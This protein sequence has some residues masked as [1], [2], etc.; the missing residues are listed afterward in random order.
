MTEC[1]KEKRITSVCLVD[2]G[3]SNHMSGAK[4]MFKD[5]DKSQKIT[6]RLGDNNEMMV[7]GK[8]TLSLITSGGK[9]KL[10]HDMQ[11]VPGLVHNLLSVS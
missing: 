6:I 5:L 3:C 1:K 4:E 10:L 8:G 7:H 2:S 9:T 11:Y